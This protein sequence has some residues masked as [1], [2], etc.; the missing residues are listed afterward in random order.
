[1]QHFIFAPACLQT[2]QVAGTASSCSASLCWWG[3]CRKSAQSIVFHNS[4]IHNRFLCINKKKSLSSHF[5]VSDVQSPTLTRF[6]M[7]VE[8]DSD[9]IFLSRSHWLWSC[10]TSPL[11]PGGLQRQNMGRTGAG[12]ML[13][14]PVAVVG[15]VPGTV[16]WCK[17]NNKNHIA[18][19]FHSVTAQQLTALCFQSGEHSFTP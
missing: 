7:N 6:D 17:T 4:H 19:D 3:Q 5:V 15:R 10:W 8:F 13:P 1:M 16:I 9:L 14:Q 12:W 11:C 18:R 2:G